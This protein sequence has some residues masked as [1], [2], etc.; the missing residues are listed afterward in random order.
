[1]DQSL[2]EPINSDLVEQNQDQTAQ[3][4]K[5]EQEPLETEDQD[6]ISD[7][8]PTSQEVDETP[9]DKEEEEKP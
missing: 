7:S 6:E 4:V 1:M 3:I 5:E 8:V 2:T 9:L